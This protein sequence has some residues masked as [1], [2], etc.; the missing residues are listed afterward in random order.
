MCD[1][2]KERSMMS[3]LNSELGTGSLFESLWT[4]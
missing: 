4:E 3:Q 1:E 2:Y